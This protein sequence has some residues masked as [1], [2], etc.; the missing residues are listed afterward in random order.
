MKRARQC[1]WLLQFGEQF[2]GM[3]DMR[4]RLIFEKA[5]IAGL[6]KAGGCVH[7]VFCIGRERDTA[8]AGEI[9][10]VWWRP[11]RRIVGTDLQVNQILLTFIILSHCRQRF[12]I[13]AFFVNT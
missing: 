1:H 6:T 10:P 12:P 2:E 7:D 8:V 4:L 11:F 3:G 5:L 9:E 13:D